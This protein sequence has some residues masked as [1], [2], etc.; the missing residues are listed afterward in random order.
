MVEID[1][2]YQGKLCCVAR[3]GPSGV[4]ITTDAP[5]D[6]Q[7][8]GASFS[9]TD[10]VATAYASCMMTILGIAANRE[11]WDFQGARACVKKSMT[12]SS[13]RRIS[14]LAVVIDMPSGLNAVARRTLENAAHGC[15]VCLSL[16]ADVE[17]SVE[18][19]YPD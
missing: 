17:T 7:G 8:Q 9:P 6:N 15:P 3:H 19:R 16:H 13:L 18:F 1:I 5:K 10:L 12:S 14:R 4:E 2:T 11:G